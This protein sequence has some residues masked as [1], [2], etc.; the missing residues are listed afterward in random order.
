MTTANPDLK[1]RADARR[2]PHERDESPDSQGQAPRGVMRQAADD[3]A[4][5]LVDTDLHGKRGVET[6]IDTGRAPGQARPRPDAGK[7]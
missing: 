2:L 6:V 7:K 3:L 1:K 5:G 4:R